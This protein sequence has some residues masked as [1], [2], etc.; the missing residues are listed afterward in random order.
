L[1]A[2]VGRFT[3]YLTTT[4]RNES[5]LDAAVA[6]AEERAAQT[7]IRFRRARGAQPAAFAASLGLGIDPT[8][9]LSRRAIERWIA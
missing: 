4:V 9:A 7:K 3:M 8:S 1:G 5:T 2:G 6:D